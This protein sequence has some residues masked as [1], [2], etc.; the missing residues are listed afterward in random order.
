MPWSGGQLAGPRTY[1][2]WLTPKLTMASSLVGNANNT[3]VAWLP[4]VM[5]RHDYVQFLQTERRFPG[6]EALYLVAQSEIERS[7]SASSSY[8][9]SILRNLID[10]YEAWNA[11]EP[12]RGH[13]LKAQEVREKLRAAEERPK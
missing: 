5:I 2:A 13:D 11:A 8:H 3:R 6:A 1:A 4:T 12:S 7:A 9:V 10:V